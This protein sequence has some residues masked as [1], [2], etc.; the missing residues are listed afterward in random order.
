MKRMYVVEKMV[1]LC[2]FASLGWSP[3]IAVDIEA[4]GN[5]IGTIN[6]LVVETTPD[7]PSRLAA[8]ISGTFHSLLQEIDRTMGEKGNFNTC[9]NRIYWSGNTSIRETAS[10]LRLSSNVRYENW[11][12]IRGLFGFTTR[13]WR[14]TKRVDWR[15][16]IDPSPI[17]QLRMS[18]QV[19]DVS[20]LPPDIEELLGL[21]IREDFQI[22]LPTN[23]GRCSCAELVDHLEPVAAATRF[24]GQEGNLHIEMEFSM[25]SDLISVLTCL[26]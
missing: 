6:A 19:E 12:C 16:F 2:I 23:C 21:R 14:T 15:I 4:N 10:S 18:A 24:S 9:G 5:V 25:S 26:R 20:D 13:I 3:A 11:L 22:P 1:G 17:D 7:D 8:R